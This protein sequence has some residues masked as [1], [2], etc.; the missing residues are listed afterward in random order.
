M[1]R[2]NDGL[3]RSNVFIEHHVERERARAVEQVMKGAFVDAVAAAII[4]RLPAMPGAAEGWMTTVQA[5]RYLG[6]SVA[7]L[8]RLTSSRAVPFV[9]DGPGAK[10]WFKASD[11]DSWRYR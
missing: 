1:P 6:L 5:A 11:L 10:C 2:D 9:Q 3:A 7:A 8:H 4:S